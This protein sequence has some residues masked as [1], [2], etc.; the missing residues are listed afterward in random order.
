MAFGAL[1]GCPPNYQTTDERETSE[2]GKRPFIHPFTPFYERGMQNPSGGR[3]DALLK[4]EMLGNS[5]QGRRHSG[6][7][8]SYATSRVSWSC[9]RSRCLPLYS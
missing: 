2:Q 9:E 1:K 5:Y 6:V 8:P 7:A 4:S 3:G